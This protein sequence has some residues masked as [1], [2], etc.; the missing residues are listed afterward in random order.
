MCV[1]SAGLS[2]AY[3]GVFKVPVSV[4]T[5]QELTEALSLFMA[6]KVPL[7]AEVALNDNVDHF[8]DILPYSMYGLERYKT[9]QI[10]HANALSKGTAMALKR[11]AD[12]IQR[13]G[14]VH[15]VMSPEDPVSFADM[16][17]YLAYL[18]SCSSGSSPEPLSEAIVSNNQ[19][20]GD[21]A[22]RVEPASDLSNSDGG[23]ERSATPANPSV[24][25]YGATGTGRKE[26]DANSDD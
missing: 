11:S 21:S 19:D 25:S 5:D 18:R 26:G 17:A 13:L 7:T 15:S 10:I 1:L 12:Y 2:A 24:T 3:E 16:R 4:I 20:G 8:D 23:G 6:R 9:Y 14:H 22:C